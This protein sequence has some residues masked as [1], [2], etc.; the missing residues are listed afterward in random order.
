MEA[1][2]LTRK[3]EE[4][5][6][7]S[8]SWPLWEALKPM[9]DKTGPPNYVLGH[10]LNRE[11]GGKGNMFNLT[12]IT[13]KANSEHSSRFE[14]DVKAWVSKGRVVYYKVT[15]DYGGRAKDKGDRERLLEARTN[16]TKPAREELAA[17]QAESSLVRTLTINAYVQ[18]FEK[19]E[20]VEDD[21]AK[22]G[23]FKNKTVENKSTA[24]Y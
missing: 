3:H 12:P 13:K 2:I 16:L 18:K 17:L 11:L 14:E 7:V 4:G 24:D 20:W 5:T 23:P 6:P 10:L 9:H 22:E 15:A 21:K 8:D 1:K 19:G